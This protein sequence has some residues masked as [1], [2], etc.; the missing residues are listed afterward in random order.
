MDYKEAI[1][2]VRQGHKVVREAWL[3]PGGGTIGG[4]TR[5]LMLVSGAEARY[6][7]IGRITIDPFV[8]QY[9]VAGNIQVYRPAH[10][11]KAA[12]DWKVF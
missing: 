4:K 10:E 11:D 2:A 1:E 7:G 12:K 6:R 3:E 5:A 8:A 9:V